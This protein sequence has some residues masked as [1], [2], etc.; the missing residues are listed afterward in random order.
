[1]DRNKE[2]NNSNIKIQQDITKGE[3]N[4][5]KKERKKVKEKEINFTLYSLNRRVFALNTAFSLL[6]EL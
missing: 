4:E 5:R 1:M 6:T 2:T 3:K